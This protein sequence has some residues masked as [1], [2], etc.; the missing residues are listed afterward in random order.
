MKRASPQHSCSTNCQGQRASYAT[1]AYFIQN[2]LPFFKVCVTLTDLEICTVCNGT[3]AI[4]V[5]NR[6]CKLLL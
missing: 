1:Q 5:N 4:R 2:Q 6:K 3:L